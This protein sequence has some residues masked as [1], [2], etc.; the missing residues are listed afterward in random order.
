MKLATLPDGTRDGRLVVVGH[1]VTQCSDARHV[2][3]TLQAALDDWQAAEPRLELIARGLEAGGQPVERFHE[4]EAHSPLPRAYQWLLGSGAETPARQVGDGFADPRAPIRTE[5]TEPRL[6]GVAVILGDMPRGAGAEAAREAIRLFV[7]FDAAQ[8]GAEAAFSP[9]AV[10]PDEMGASWDGTRLAGFAPEPLDFIAAI[11]A[12]ARS[13]ALA[14]GSVIGLVAGTGGPERTRLEMR[15]AG[16]HSIL[17]A[18]ERA[19][20]ALEVPA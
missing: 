20:E 12:A 6:S 1:D 2:A 13:H 7:L 4:R 5:G 9:V 11:V 18:I 19:R 17:G 3:P 15:D 14:A 8:G 16:G 10:T